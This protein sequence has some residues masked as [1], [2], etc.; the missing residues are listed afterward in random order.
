M[1]V[2]RREGGS[3]RTKKKGKKRKYHAKDR[4]RDLLISYQK[5]YIK[6]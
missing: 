5:I 2:P 3:L 1:I 4:M 6:F